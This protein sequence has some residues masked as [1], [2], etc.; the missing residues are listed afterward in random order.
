MVGAR[1]GNAVGRR[2]SGDRTRPDPISSL[3]AQQLPVRE[4]GQFQ[5]HPGDHE[6]RNALRRP[7]WQ[8]IS[9]EPPDLPRLGDLPPYG[10]FVAM[11]P[12]VAP[13]ADSRS[14]PAVFADQR[15]FRRGGRRGPQR[16]PQPPPESVRRAPTVSLSAPAAGASWSCS[17]AAW[18]AASWS[19]RWID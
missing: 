16:K 6:T 8:F 3:D 1:P 11:A 5:G 12:V 13:S 7:V 14:W 2:A 19:P 15:D 4:L 9:A 10:P 17:R 18:P